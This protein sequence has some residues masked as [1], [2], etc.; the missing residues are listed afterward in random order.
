MAA[1]AVQIENLVDYLFHCRNRH[2]GEIQKYESFGREVFC[3]HGDH[4]LWLCDDGPDHVRDYV[5]S[6]D[7]EMIA[8]KD[9]IRTSYQKSTDDRPPFRLYKTS[10]KCQISF[11]T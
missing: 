3:G 11:S 6:C 9:N 5:S 1:Y 10:K 4:R 8:E 2:D 7:G